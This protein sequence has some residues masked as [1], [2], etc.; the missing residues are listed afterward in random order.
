[1][2]EFNFLEYLKLEKDL[3]E[4]GNYYDPND[5]YNRK[6]Y[7]PLVTRSGLPARILCIDRVV[8]SSKDLPE[9]PEKELPTGYH[10]SVL[11]KLKKGVEE[12]RRYNSQG[13]CFV[14]KDEDVLC[15]T[16]IHHR[17]RVIYRDPETDLPS[18]KDF[19]TQEEALKFYAEDPVIK[20]SLMPYEVTLSD[21]D[22]LDKS[23]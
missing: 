21:V 17:W 5:I 9:D 18:Y 4:S 6:K 12:S 19:L 16:E 2:K 11:V 10:I 1:M 13:R 20:E 8:S 3:L 23:S 7:V 15:F 14:D 22:L